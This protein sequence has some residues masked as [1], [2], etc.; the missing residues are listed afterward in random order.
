LLKEFRDKLGTE[1]ARQNR[2]FG[3]PQVF[4]QHPPN[5]TTTQIR[6]LGKK[7]AT[8]ISSTKEESGIGT[9]QNARDEVLTSKE[10]LEHHQLT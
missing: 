8:S 5:C 6:E 4:C 9:L 7:R 3:L 1:A 2:T 10:R